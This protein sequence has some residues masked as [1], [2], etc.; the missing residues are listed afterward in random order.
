MELH[1]FSMIAAGPGAQGEVVIDKDYE[2]AGVRL[3]G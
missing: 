2:K 3:T 1:P